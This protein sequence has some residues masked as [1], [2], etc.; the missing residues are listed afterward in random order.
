MRRGVTPEE[1]QKLQVLNDFFIFKTPFIQKICT[2]P[3]TPIWY[4][5]LYI[6]LLVDFGYI[7]YEGFFFR[8][9]PTYAFYESTVTHVFY[10]IFSIDIIL[11]LFY[12]LNY[13]NPRHRPS[14]YFVLALEISSLIPIDVIMAA[15]MGED[16][17]PLNLYNG[18]IRVS[19]PRILRVARIFEHFIYSHADIG[20]PTL[21]S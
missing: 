3:F 11:M 9:P 16:G 4:I 5:P 17:R 20:I 15:R 1:A 8:F 18:L 14:S 6:W 12:K 2:T 13:H 21:L 19:V 7:L 10:C